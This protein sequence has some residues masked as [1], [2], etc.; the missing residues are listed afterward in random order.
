[1]FQ[2]TAKDLSL[3][4]G[5]TVNADFRGLHNTLTTTYDHDEG[6][7]ISVRGAGG[8]GRDDRHGN[9]GP[10]LERHAYRLPAGDISVTARLGGTFNSFGSGPCAQVTQQKADLDRT[11]GLASLSVDVPVFDSPH[12]SW[13]GSR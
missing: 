2:R 4:L 8:R 11:T 3:H 10:H 5:S 7:T 9:G 12:R 13:A 6:R 1:V